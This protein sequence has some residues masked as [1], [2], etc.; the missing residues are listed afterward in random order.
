[1]NSRFDVDCEEAENIFRMLDTNQDEELEYAE[2]LAAVVSN[3]TCFEGALRGAFSHFD[4]NGDGKIDQE[5]LSRMLGVS[6]TESEISRLFR[7]ADTS[8]DGFLDYNEFA[9]RFHQ[10]DA[11]FEMDEDFM[12][13][14]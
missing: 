2:F 3:S 7:G 9:V 1:M 5:E 6:L 12:T 13:V 14:A 8:G 4:R 10:P 11:E